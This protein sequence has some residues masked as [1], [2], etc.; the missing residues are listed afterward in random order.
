MRGLTSASAWAMTA[1]EGDAVEVVD[2][3]ALEKLEDK[4][5][6]HAVH[7]GHGQD[8]D[9]VVAALERLA[10]HVEG[11]VGVAPQRPVG[12]HHALGAPGGAAGVVDE[13]QLLGAVLVVADVAALEGLRIF[14]AEELIK[15]FAREGERL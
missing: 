8:A 2:M 5:E 9:D 14:F 12:Q 3:H 4:L 13:G 15:M 7:V 6:R 1:G 10:Q 11:E